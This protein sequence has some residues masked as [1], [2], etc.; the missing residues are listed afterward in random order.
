MWLCRKIVALITLLALLAPSGLAQEHLDDIP[1]LYPGLSWRKLALEEVDFNLL[2]FDNRKFRKEGTKE[3]SDYVHL[4][5]RVWV[6]ESSE[7]VRREFYGY[8]DSELK[9]RGWKQFLSI[10]SDKHRMTLH[11][12]FADGT[13]GSIWSYAALQGD[14][15][16]VVVLARHLDEAT[17]VYEFHV[18]LS[19][20]VPLSDILP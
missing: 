1:E 7:R 6:S 13:T 19:D 2:Y 3:I 15:V 14:N 4:N 10:T 9:K 11:G 5:G 16:R 8:Y 20:I 18:F 12:V 17:G